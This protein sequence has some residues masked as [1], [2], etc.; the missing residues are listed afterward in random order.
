[1]NMPYLAR[2][3][4][5]SL[6]GIDVYECFQDHELADK[7]MAQVSD[8]LERFTPLNAQRFSR[9]LDVACYRKMTVGYE[10]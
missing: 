6:S 8:D 3:F 4:Q 7:V 1:M 2:A 9:L 10:D 5:F